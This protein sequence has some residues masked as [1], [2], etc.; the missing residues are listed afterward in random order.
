M[1]NARFEPVTI[2]NVRVTRE[3]DHAILCVIDDEE[4]MD[5]FW[6]PKSQIKDESEVYSLKSG[7]DP[8]T[9]VIPQ[10]L[11]DEKGIG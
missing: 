11:A 1:S 2:E 7:E 5:G 4:G 6:I 9:L 8:G 10:W 3:T